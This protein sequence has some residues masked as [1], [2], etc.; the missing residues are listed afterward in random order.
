MAALQNP[1]SHSRQSEPNRRDPE[2][3]KVHFVPASLEVTNRAQITPPG[4]C[5]LEA[6]ALASLCIKLDLFKH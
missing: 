3:E 4:K 6:E 2:E 5:G 1:G